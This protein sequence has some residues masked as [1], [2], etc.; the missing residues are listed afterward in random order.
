TYPDEAPESN[1]SNDWRADEVSGSKQRDHSFHC[2][3]ETDE[4]DRQSGERQPTAFLD[5]DLTCRLFQ[6]FAGTA[7]RT[8]IGCRH[9]RPPCGFGNESSRGRSAR[10][11][12]LTACST[13]A[14]QAE[15]R[16]L[17]SCLRGSR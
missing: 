5:L 1:R 10:P 13:I 12:P 11:R 7:G 6:V 17:R 3:P 4:L 9:E 2:V 16:W 15:L 8:P 14:W